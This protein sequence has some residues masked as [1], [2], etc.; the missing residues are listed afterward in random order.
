MA[1]GS[2]GG[3]VGNSNSTPELTY[4]T[5]PY[6]VRMGGQK[7]STKEERKQVTETITRFI[8][9]AKPGQV[10]TVGGGFGSG[11]S[12]F[13]VVGS[14]RGLELKWLSESGSRRSVK[15]NRANVKDFIFNGAKL[16]RVE[17]SPY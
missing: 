16:I 8:D 7:F 3:K 17:K 5:M 10:Y 9:N 6:W 2:R 4:E 13:K 15:L 11:E 14:G 1:K 12:Q